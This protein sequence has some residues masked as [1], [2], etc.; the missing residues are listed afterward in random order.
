MRYPDV[1]VT[2]TGRS[3]TSFTAY[4]LQERLGVCMAHSFDPPTK[5]VARGYPY[6]VGGYEE[7]SM[8]ALTDRFVNDRDWRESGWLSTFSALHEGCEGLVGI[9]QWRLAGASLE[10]WKHINPGL[11]VRTF[12]PEEPTVRSMVR[13]RRSHREDHWRVFYRKLEENMRRV[14]DHPG[15]PFPVV[16]VDFSEQITEE[17]VE[18][19][20][21]F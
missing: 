6:K 4:V 3:G 18:G 20:L 19:L 15:F 5:K 12:R 16:R 9:K 14:I 13:Y 7:R 17:R 11:V 8:L 2:G 1:V 21:C 10:H